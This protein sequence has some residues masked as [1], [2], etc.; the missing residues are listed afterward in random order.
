MKFDRRKIYILLRIAKRI[1][2][3]FNTKI[4][5]KFV[6]EKSCL[7]FMWTIYQYTLIALLGLWSD[8]ANHYEP[9]I[10]LTL[11]IFKLH[12]SGS[13]EKHVLNIMD[14]PHKRN[15]KTEYRL[16]SNC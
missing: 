10:N 15:K 4:S 12:V 16:S 13:R 3:P 5:M 6:L 14:L 11:L 9:I 2:A 8:N 1:Y 7:V